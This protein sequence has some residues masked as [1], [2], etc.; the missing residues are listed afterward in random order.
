MF[1]QRLGWSHEDCSTL[2][3]LSAGVVGLLMLLTVCKPLTTLRAALLIAVTIAFVGAVLLLGRI[4][5]L[6]TL[7]GPRLMALVLLTLGAACVLSLSSGVMKRLQRKP[8]APAEAAPPA[9]RSDP[10][11]PPATLPPG[12]SGQKA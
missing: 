11:A 3:T 5:L 9:K 8:A 1:C 10:P 4:F 6:T 7:T 12:V 2:A